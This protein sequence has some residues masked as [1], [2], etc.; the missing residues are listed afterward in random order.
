MKIMRPQTL[1]D[2]K[3]LDLILNRL[4][5][6]LIENHDD[7]QNSVILGLQPRGI[8]LADRI[9]SKLEKLIPNQQIECGHLDITFFRDDF[10]RRKAPLN[11][12]STKIDF[13]IEGKKVILVD[14]VLYTGRTIRS[15][16]DAM[17][18]YGRPA[19]VELMVLIDRRFSRELPI[20]PTYIGKS[21]DSYDS[22][23]VE[24]CFT[25]E[26]DSDKVI[27]FTTKK[28]DEKA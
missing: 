14:D 24:V 23:K 16:L 9:K 5:C 10:R 2:S 4:C 7:F 12:N 25:G 18:S 20:E 8:E 13:L 17:L 22:Q 28:E 19:V 11:P 27:L 26:E 3:Q 15:G 6:Q 21:I 1:I